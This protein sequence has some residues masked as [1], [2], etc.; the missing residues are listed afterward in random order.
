MAARVFLHV[1]TVFVLTAAETADLPLA[2][3]LGNLPRPNLATG[4]TF[5]ETLYANIVTPSIYTHTTALSPYRSSLS[6]SAT[7]SY[8]LQS[9][10][11]ISAGFAGL[12]LSH[13]RTIR[14]V[15]RFSK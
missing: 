8:T 15:P 3:I 14:Q 2:Q 5:T 11:V 12:V 9:R 10:S 4:P 1:N 13:I 7:R 6:N